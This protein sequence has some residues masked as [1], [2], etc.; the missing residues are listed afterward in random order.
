M[1][2]GAESPASSSSMWTGLAWHPHH[3]WSPALEYPAYG[4]W[5]AAA[6]SR[7]QAL[8]KQDP[9]LRLHP[10]L[11]LQALAE[12]CFLMPGSASEQRPAA[13]LGTRQPPC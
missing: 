11:L 6:D 10:V 1:G 4:V 12:L 3:L 7:G 9:E 13:T 5:E 2:M 8:C